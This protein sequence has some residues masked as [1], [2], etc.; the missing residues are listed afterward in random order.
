M[1][2]TYLDII[3]YAQ[4]ISTD[5][6]DIS[7]QLPH[8]WNI[9]KYKSQLENIIVQ[10]DALIQAKMMALYPLSTLLGT[11][12]RVTVPVPHRR[13][14]G[15]TELVSVLLNDVDD[16]HTAAWTLNFTSDTTYNIYSSLEGLQGT[17]WDITDITNTS[18]NGEITIEDSFWMENKADFIRSDQILFSIHR[19]HPLIQYIS[20]LL[21]TSMAL[22][23]VYVAESPNESNFGKTLWDKA[24]EIIEEL[25][26]GEATLDENFPAYDLSTIPIQYVINDLGRDISPYLTDTSF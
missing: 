24:M 26:K 8:L 2:S 17:D 19:S 23:T 13:N 18:S 12:G 25:L 11:T 16:V 9:V 4:Q 14:Q 3:L 1:F 6:V 21:A 10:V 7:D 22:T 5:Q 15:D 20:N